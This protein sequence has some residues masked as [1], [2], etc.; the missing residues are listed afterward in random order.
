MLCDLCN[1]PLASVTNRMPAII[2]Q[3]AV[4]AGLRPDGAAAT[5]MQMQ[6]ALHGAGSTMRTWLAMVQRNQTDWAL[7]PPCNARAV[8]FLADG[9]EPTVSVGAGAAA[10]YPLADTAA[11]QKPQSRQSARTTLILLVVAAAFLAAAYAVYSYVDFPDPT[12]RLVATGILCFI[13]ASNLFI[14]VAG[15]FDSRT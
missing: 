6:D 14:T 8:S 12:S 4:E 11:T 2:F 7:C 1:A 13:G 15:A 3:M 9:R 10:A 5:F